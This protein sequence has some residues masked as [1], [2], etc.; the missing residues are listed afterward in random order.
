MPPNSM[1]P[2]MA[3]E[4]VTVT[5]NVKSADQMAVPQETNYYLYILQSTLNLLAH[6]LIGVVVGICLLFSL[7]G[8]LPLG[9]TF[10]HII[11]CVIGYQL[12]MGQA[13]LTLA[14][15]NGWAAKLRLVDKRRAHWILQIMGSALALAGSLVK[16]LDKEVH[17]NTNHGRFALVA[18]VFTVASL[19]NGLTSLYAYEFR[20]IFNGNISKL[21][22]VCFGIVTFTTASITLCHGFDKNF[23]RI[24]ASDEFAN[25]LI[26]FTAVYT[27]IIIINPFITFCSKASNAIRR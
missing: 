15:G 9:A 5:Q 25:V 22:H 23:F 8:G 2:T 16:V 20:R 18:I 13:I 17:W 24:W 12:L 27:I 10:T 4:P 3:P 21:T 14:R 19:V 1:E 6:V 7:R 11:L 26:A